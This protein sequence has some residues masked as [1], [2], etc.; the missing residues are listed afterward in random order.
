MDGI[1]ARVLWGTAGW[2]PDPMRA[3]MRRWALTATAVVVVDAAVLAFAGAVM[4]LSGQLRASVGNLLG[5]LSL[6]MGAV[7]PNALVGGVTAILGVLGL[8]W[9]QQ[10]LFAPAL[11]GNAG[12]GLPALGAALAGPLYTV[13]RRVAWRSRRDAD[14]QGAPPHRVYLPAMAKALEPALPASTAVQ[15]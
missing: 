14:R 13:V 7:L 4:G 2:I 5:G 12:A 8:G 3:Q 1:I 15:E 9:W 11:V 6:V 10:N